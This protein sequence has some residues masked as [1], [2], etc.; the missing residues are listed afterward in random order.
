MENLRLGDWAMILV[1]GVM[2]IFIGVY[3]VQYSRKGVNYFAGGRKIPWWV[4]GVSSWM[5]AFS[6]YVFVGLA[7]AVYRVGVAPLFHI[8]LSMSFAWFAG[9]FL[10]AARWRKTGIIT[11][12]EF[13]E[14]RFNLTARQ[15]F[16]WVVT[17]FRIMDDG[18]KCY[19][20]ALIIATVFGIPYWYSILGLS[21][22]TVAYTMMGGLWAVMIT[23]IVQFVILIVVVFVVLPIGLDK[24]GWLS[25]LGS[26]APEGFYRIFHEFD[27]YQGEF[28]IW[29]FAAMWVM[30]PLLYNGSFSLVQR[31]TTV[32]TPR[33]AVKSAWL[34]MS[35]GLVFFPFMIGPP[36]ISRL[37]Y[38]DA[39]MGSTTLMETSY[40]KLCLDLLPVGMIGMVVVAL[41][42][43]T[44][45]SLAGDYNIYG[46]VLTN[47]LYHRL[48]NR[49]AGQRRLAVVGKF[50]TL[51][52]GAL[53]MG[54]ALLIPVMGGAFKV[55]MN[56]L[57]MIGGPTTIPILLGLWLRR[58][59]P[60]AAIAACVSGVVFGGAT[61]F[62]L[63]WPYAPFVLGNIAVTTVVFLGWGLLFPVSGRLKEKVDALFERVLRADKAPEP[64]QEDGAV[65]S[66]SEAE[67]EKAPSPYAIVGYI[68]AATGL[69]LGLIGLGGG[70]GRGMLIDGLVGALLV[71]L[72][73]LMVMRGRA[74]RADG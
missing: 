20:T 53:A 57:G 12:P 50:N 32:P 28:T 14:Q 17:P 52:V 41:M 47:D 60:G 6:A 38:G 25:G 59:G 24:I 11:V 67:D 58:S 10:W 40:I 16:A 34:S 5:S 61:R 9:A 23:D 1:Y 37:F 3:C 71:V 26:G 73:G 31:Y 42:A 36:V 68:L 39:L 64:V 22:V 4:S 70:T 72:G 19:A 63:Q 49:R 33:D 18:V 56:I 46:A 21:L 66:E 55:M 43:A 35:L 62:I 27:T 15:V 8:L 44:M 30:T 48:I 2:M 74:L 51:L 29:F 7:S 69:T 45:S 54:I 65:V 13:M